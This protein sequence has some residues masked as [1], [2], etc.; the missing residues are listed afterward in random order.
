MQIVNASNVIEAINN[1]K[2][3]HSSLFYNMLSENAREFTHLFINISYKVS[4]FRD[5][6]TFVKTLKEEVLSLFYSVEY[7]EI[8]A[9]FFVN[10]SAKLTDN[11]D[12]LAIA[13][14]IKD[15]ILSEFDTN[16]IAELYVKA[17]FIALDGIFNENKQF[18]IIKEI[19]I[20]LKRYNTNEIAEIYLSALKCICKTHPEHE[21]LLEEI[22]SIQNEYGISHDEAVSS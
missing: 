21:H 15:E 1:I 3:M 13:K 12:R 11:K 17:L 18:D 4:S 5:I 20:V 22:E 14:Y 2:R 10:A 9:K 6:L 19:K 16:I 8:Y 7:A